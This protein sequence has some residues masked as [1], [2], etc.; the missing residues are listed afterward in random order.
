MKKEY[1]MRCEACHSIQSFTPVAWGAG[2]EC[3]KCHVVF[4]ARE[5]TRFETSINE[6]SNVP[7]SREEFNALTARLAQAEEWIRH[8][9]ASSMAM[10][11]RLEEIKRQC[12]ANLVKLNGEG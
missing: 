11:P 8:Y 1:L 4:D 2:M 7:V 6:P 9:E 12:D 3:N 5:K 10:L